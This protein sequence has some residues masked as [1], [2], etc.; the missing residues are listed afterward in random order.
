MIR[1]IGARCIM[2]FKSRKDG[3]TRMCVC[4]SAVLLLLQ[5]REGYISGG[6]AV[7]VTSGYLTGSYAQ[8]N[9]S[10]SQPRLMTEASSYVALESAAT[11]TVTMAD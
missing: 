3:S 10:K 11:G 2:W 9:S 4:R 7:P 1:S 6:P 5:A 8:P